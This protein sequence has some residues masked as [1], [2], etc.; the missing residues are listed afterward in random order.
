M[1][2]EPQTVLIAIGYP[3]TFVASETLQR[4]F[5]LYNPP[6]WV[7]LRREAFRTANDNGEY[8]FDDFVFLENLSTRGLTSDVEVVYPL[9]NNDTN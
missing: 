2:Q 4:N 8:E 5:E 1:E 6:E 9:V 7:Q 3:D